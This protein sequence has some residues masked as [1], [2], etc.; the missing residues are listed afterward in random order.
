VS[1]AKAI[2]T[3]AWIIGKDFVHNT[4]ILH[5]VIHSYIVYQ[6]P[7]SEAMFDIAEGT[8]Y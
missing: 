7:N 5:H 3:S 6:R 8:G 4:I 1:T 2:D